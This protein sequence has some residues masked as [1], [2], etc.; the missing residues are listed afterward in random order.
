MRQLKP[1]PPSIVRDTKLNHN[2]T[3]HYALGQFAGKK[4]VETDKKR[5]NAVPTDPVGVTLFVR[6]QPSSPWKPRFFGRIPR[7]F[8]PLVPMNYLAGY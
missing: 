3:M 6:P 4:S 8:L 2:F 7:I 5:E 1:L